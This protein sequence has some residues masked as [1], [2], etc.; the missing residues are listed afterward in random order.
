M[1]D[2]PARP[3]GRFF[4]RHLDFFI[5][6]RQLTAIYLDLVPSSKFLHEPGLFNQLPG[7]AKA[8]T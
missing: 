1:A 4:A 5:M 8:T 3:A 7:Q 2:L 6:T